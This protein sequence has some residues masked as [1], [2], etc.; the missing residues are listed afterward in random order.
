MDVTKPYYVK[1]AYPGSNSYNVMNGLVRNAF[2]DPQCV[3][4]GLSLKDAEQYRAELNA[5]YAAGQEEPQYKGH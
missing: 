2:G 3:Q 1:S 4:M 5:A